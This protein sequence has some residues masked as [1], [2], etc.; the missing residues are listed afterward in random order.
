MF[1]RTRSSLGRFACPLMFSFAL[2]AAGCQHHFDPAKYGEVVPELPV[3]KGADRPYDMPELK[4]P[5][6][7]KTPTETPPDAPAAATSPEPAT[8]AAPEK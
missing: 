6:D 5:L 3:V 2:L 8:K 1:T 7:P 4:Q